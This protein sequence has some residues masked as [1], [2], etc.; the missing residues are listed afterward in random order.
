LGGRG[1]T[2]SSGRASGCGKASGRGRTGY[3]KAATPILLHIDPPGAEDRHYIEVIGAGAG[4]DG[5]DVD[6]LPFLGG[7]GD[8]LVVCGAIDSYEQAS[9]YPLL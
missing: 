1:R 2:G 8:E 3:R 7:A 5:K 4:V 6:A 9:L